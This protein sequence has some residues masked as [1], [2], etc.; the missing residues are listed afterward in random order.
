MSFSRSLSRRHFLRTASACSLGFLGL[1]QLVGCAPRKLVPH[2]RWGPILRDPARVL[3]LP[4]GFRYH[5]VSRV[6]D[7]M[8]DGFR[9]PHRAD[10]MA[11]FPG[12][13]GMTLV[14]RNHEVSSKANWA[15]GAFGRGNSMMTKLTA[16]QIYDRGADGQPCLGGT[17]TFVYD[18]R[19]QTL[20]REF[21]SLTGTVRNCAG[22]P[23]PWQSWITCEE[24]VQ[25]AGDGNCTRD[26]G[27]CFEVPATAHPTLAA[28]VPLK[29]MGRFNHEAV[30]VHPDSGIV[31]QTE[32]S[33]TGLLYRFLPNTPGELTAG[34][35][36]QALA[37]RDRPSAD[38]RN[39]S[40]PYVPLQES[41]SVDWLDLDEVE[42]P[43]NDLRLRGFADGAARFARGE[44]MWYGNDAVYF[45][46][47][48]GG[49]RK[50]GQVWRYVPS[51][52][53]GT[54]AEQAA[55]GMLQ[56]FVESQDPGL[57]E[58]CDNLT[59]APWGDVVLCEDG[60]G[61]QY[62]VGVTPDGAIYQF[63]RNATGN[64]EMAGATFS[65]DGT[66]LFVNI[67]HEGLTLAITGPWLG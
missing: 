9:V 62:L 37:L 5:I 12:P 39:W 54:P 56:L 33:H 4:Q 30:A 46:C 67:Q 11:A 41:F 38:T 7:L 53:E 47:T 66:T 32:D 51:T 2:A 36:L 58:N 6:G 60:S 3:D 65:P 19:N 52:A 25:R 61:D 17:T 16:P 13:D 26:H 24:T 55:P 22:G 63:A 40:A 57:I 28:P 42:N 15:E 48:N 18:T 43:N 27:Y 20:V 45:A 29:A 35:R 10:G 14:V 31:Y 59:V 1:S 34:G 21:L 49:P 64:S 50:L 8:A 23:T 44:G